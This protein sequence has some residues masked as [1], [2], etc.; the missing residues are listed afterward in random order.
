MTRIAWIALFLIAMPTVALTEGIRFVNGRLDA[1]AV[2][3]LELTDDQ[4]VQVRTK[5]VVILTAAQKAQLAKAKVGPS[6]LT[7]YSKKQ[8]SNGIDSCFEYNMAL[9]FEPRRIE[10]PHMFL[11]SDEQA[12]AKAEDIENID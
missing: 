6:V 7:V 4:L 11:V 9:W 1:G 5:R 8:A 2:T 12:A 3:V 10:V